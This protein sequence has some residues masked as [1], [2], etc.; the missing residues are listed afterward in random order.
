M[1]PVN[2]RRNQAEKRT[3]PFYHLFAEND[4]SYYVAYVSEQNLR[5]DGRGGPVSHP[6][7]K[8]MFTGLDGHTYKPKPDFAH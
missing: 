7:I 4:E 3:S 8:Q 6:Q 1:V 5:D 2:S